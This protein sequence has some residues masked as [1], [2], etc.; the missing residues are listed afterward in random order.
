VFG[1]GDEAIVIEGQNLGGG[2]ASAVLDLDVEPILV[3]WYSGR[4]RGE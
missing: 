1:P 4:L 3:H 2:D